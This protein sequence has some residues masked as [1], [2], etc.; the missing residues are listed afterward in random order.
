[1]ST[2]PSLEVSQLTDRNLF[3]R[4]Q[5]LRSIQNEI[6]PK[7]S[8]LYASGMPDTPHHFKTGDWVYVGRHQ[9]QSLELQWKRAFL[10]LL[11]LHNPQGHWHCSLGAHFPCETCRCPT[12][13]KSSLGSTEDGQSAQAQDFPPLHWTRDTVKWQWYF[14]LPGCFMDLNPHQPFNLT[15]IVENPETGYRAHSK[16]PNN[17]WVSPGFLTKYLIYMNWL[18][19]RGQILILKRP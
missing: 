10:V 12:P 5:A 3:L 2:R 18:K 7:L 19:V 16:P 17:L 6:W 14:L 8:A 13:W 15:W 9:A 4:F 11:T 1:M